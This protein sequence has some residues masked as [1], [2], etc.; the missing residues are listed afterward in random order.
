MHHG[1][2]CFSRVAVRCAVQVQREL[3][4]EQGTRSPYQIH[5]GAGELVERDNV[6]SLERLCNWRR[7][8]VLTPND[9]PGLNCGSANYIGRA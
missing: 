9:R 7:G 4:G 1:L 3:V 5:Y 8:F 6:I 2:F